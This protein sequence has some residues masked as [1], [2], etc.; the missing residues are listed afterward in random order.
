MADDLQRHLLP[1][2]RELDPLI[3]RVVHKPQFCQSLEHFADGG[4]AHLNTNF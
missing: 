2:R 3:G 4:G 1:G